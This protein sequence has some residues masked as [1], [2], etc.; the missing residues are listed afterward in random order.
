MLFRSNYRNMVQ[1][2]GDRVL[3]QIS[4]GKTLAQIKA[5]KLT[6]DFDGIYG[7]PDAFVEAI[8]KSSQKKK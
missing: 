8:F 2:I 4:K 6:L 3:D 5:A 7:S 1:I